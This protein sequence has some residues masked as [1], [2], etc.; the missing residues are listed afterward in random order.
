[1][2]YPNYPHPV[3]MPAP[4]PDCHG[5]VFRGVLIGIVLELVVIGS[6]VAFAFWG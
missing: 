6:I 5:G 4:E 2:N 1:M 3:F